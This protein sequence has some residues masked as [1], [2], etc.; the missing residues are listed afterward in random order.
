MER[1]N[2]GILVLKDVFHFSIPIQNDFQ[3]EAITLFFQNPLFQ[4][5]TIPLFQLGRSH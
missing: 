2:D 4:C 3:H 1:W 5:S